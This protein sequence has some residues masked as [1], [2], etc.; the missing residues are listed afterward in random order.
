MFAVSA[1][2]RATLI[3]TLSKGVFG[4]QG[5][6]RTERARDRQKDRQRD[7]RTVR[8]PYAQ[9]EKPTDRHMIDCDLLHLWLLSDLLLLLANLYEMHSILSLSSAQLVE[10]PQ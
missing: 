7:I 1:T 5:D 9:S 3:K 6:K 2:F 4:V 8:E 10:E